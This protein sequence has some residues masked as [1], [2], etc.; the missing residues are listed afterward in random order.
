ML[1]PGA[2]VARQDGVEARS[3]V[4]VYSTESLAE[5]LEVTGPVRLIVHVATTAVATDVTG[6]LVDVDEGGVAVNVCDGILRRPYQ[7]GR[8]DEITV[9]LW[10]TSMVFRKGHR[11]RLEV[12]S[13]NH[14]RFDRHPNTGRPVATETTSVTA[15]QTIFHNA[16]QPSR[17]I[18][19]VIPAA[20][21]R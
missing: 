1:G 15:T 8:A 19:P 20:A 18:L 21:V 16:A 3:D 13:S 5:D 4:L 2:G 6:K 12:S 9:E 11:V 10:P 14:P 7:P 17:L